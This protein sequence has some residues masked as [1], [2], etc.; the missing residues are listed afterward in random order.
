[1]GAPTSVFGQRVMATSTSVTMASDQPPVPVSGTFGPPVVLGQAAMAASLPVVLASDQTNLPAISLVTPDG[2]TYVA[3]RTPSVFK[4]LAA[5]LITAQTTIW[6]PAAG[7]KFRLMGF[8]ITQGVLA[9]NVTLKDNTG[10]T[11]ILVIPSTPI[12]QPLS[13]PLGNGILSAAANNVLTATG[14]ATET[15]SGFVYGCEE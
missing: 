11:T 3:A 12:G 5:V 10:G 7:K 1:M 13:V 8:V 2:A 6:T 9:G 14:S 15:I 4:S